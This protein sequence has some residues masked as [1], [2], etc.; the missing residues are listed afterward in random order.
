MLFLVGCSPGATKGPQYDVAKLQSGEIIQTVTATGTLSAVVSVDVGSQ[1]SGKVKVLNADFNSTVKKGAIVA[2]IDSALYSAA[3]HQAMGDLASA[4][5]ARELSRL[6]L[7]RKKLLVSQHAATQADLDKAVADLAQA[8]A[9]VTIKEGALEKAQADLSYCKIYAPVDGIVISRKVDLGQTVA[10]AMTTPVLFTIAQDITLMHISATVSE[11]DIGLVRPGQKAEF[12]VD[13]FPA[14]VFVGNVVQVRMAATTTNNVVTYDTIIDVSNPDRKLF[15][16]MT[17]TVTIVATRRENA[18]KIPNAAL[19]FAPPEG[20]KLSVPQGSIPQLQ[21]TQRLVYALESDNSTLR[22]VVITTGISNGVDTEVISGLK[23]G[24]SVV[25][26]A[27]A[28]KPGG[29][30]FGPPPIGN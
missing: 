7:D 27:N 9:M 5:A 26:A 13:A 17:A 23:P 18:L 6:T 10:A 29:G 1:I 11:A 2:E 14:E 15:P 3:L 28:K 24:D 21:R 19:R 16:G 30:G 4:K 22:P 20:A 12:T 25:T 8:D